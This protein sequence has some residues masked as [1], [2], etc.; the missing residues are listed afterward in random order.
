MSR[1]V[2]IAALA[3]LA[4]LSTPS[5]AQVPPFPSRASGPTAWTSLSVGLLRIPTMYDPAS[6]ATWDFGNVVQFRGT[7]EREFRRGASVGV[8]ASLARAPLT[9]VGPDCGSCDAD[10]T[11]WQAL[12]LF[13]IGGGGFGLHQIIE[14]GAGV[15]GFSGFRA[16]EGGDIGSGTTIDPTVTLGFGLGYS[17]SPT[18]QFTFVQEF[19]LMVHERGDRPAGDESNLPIANTTRIGLRVGLGGWR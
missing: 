12:A 16:R 8:A 5:L 7:L 14:V 3:L 17:R 1:R 11:L 4:V 10:A 9:Y 2:V 13:R 15:T 6:E 19:G 18:T